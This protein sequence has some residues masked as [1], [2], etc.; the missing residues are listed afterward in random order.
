MRVAVMFES[1][2]LPRLN[3]ERVGAC[4]LAAGFLMVVIAPRG[5]TRETAAKWRGWTVYL[6]IVGD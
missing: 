3:T 6:N 2:K 1:P 4:R 5:G